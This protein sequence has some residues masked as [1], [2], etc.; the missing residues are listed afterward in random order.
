MPMMPSSVSASLTSSSLNGLMMASIFFIETSVTVAEPRGEASSCR[1]ERTR[2][3]RRPTRSPPS[4]RSGPARSRARAAG[5][6]SP[7]AG[8]TPAWRRPRTRRRGSPCPCGAWDRTPSRC[9]RARPC[10]PRW[11]PRRSR[12][13]VAR[14]HE[15]AV[16][17]A[18]DAA[19]ERGVVAQAQGDAAGVLGRRTHP[20]LLEIRLPGAEQRELAPRLENGGQAFEGEVE[21]LLVGEACDHG[22]DGAARVLETQFAPQGLAAGCLALGLV[23]AVRTGQRRVLG[24]IPLLVVD[25][26]DHAV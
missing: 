10:A 8:R 9:P 25:A 21:P 26:V 15:E 24:G 6:R 16:G 11:A 13:R 20:R 3:P 22:H 17:A 18:V 23:R 7:R 14:G 2:G 4:S 19:P 5:R 1:G 12:G